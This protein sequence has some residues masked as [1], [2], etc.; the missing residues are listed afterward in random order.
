[1][2]TGDEAISPALGNTPR[3]SQEGQQSVR[4]SSLQAVMMLGCV[5]S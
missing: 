3:L 2:M 5:S 1:M 4:F